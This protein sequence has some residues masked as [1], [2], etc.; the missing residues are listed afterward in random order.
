MPVLL[1]LPC[2]FALREVPVVEQGAQALPLAVN[3]EQAQ[4]LALPVVLTRSALL[5]EQAVRLREARQEER[6]AVEYRQPRQLS[7]AALEVCRRNLI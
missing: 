1:A 4:C 7:R 3:Q 2:V 6:V 5:G